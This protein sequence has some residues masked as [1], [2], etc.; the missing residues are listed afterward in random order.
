M[1]N[2]KLYTATFTF[3]GRRHYVRSS[4]SQRDAERKALQKENALKD[5]LI[6]LDENTTFAEYAQQWYETYKQNTVSKPVAKSYISRIR[7]HLNPAIG[8]MKLKDIRPIHL[9]KILNN[10]VGKSKSHVDKM[11][12]TIRQIFYQATRDKLIREDPACDLTL[13]NATDGTHRSITSEERVAIL[14]AATRHPFGLFVK[15]LLWCGLRPQEAAALEWSGIDQINRRICVRQA[16]KKDNSIGETKTGAGR[17]DVPIPDSLWK[18]LKPHIPQNADG[19]IFKH[20][21]GDRHTHTSL[22]RAWE[23]FMREVDMELGAET[24]VFYGKP[25]IVKSV[26]APDL[27]LYCLRHTYCTDLEAAGV[28][29]NVAKYLMGHSSIAMTSR[30]Y[31]HMRPDTLEAVAERINAFGATVGATPK[32]NLTTQIDRKDGPA[33]ESEDGQIVC[34]KA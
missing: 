9:Q 5:G 25:R 13:P 33:A 6:I 16:L 21:R 32:L 3:E 19:Y 10:Q 30:I 29:I 34:I 11:R 27:T 24:D 14:A 31:T 8:Q 17:R 4:K 18:D 1:P 22:R 23:S 12:V 2:K 26:R 20:S 28:P 15:T 7:Q